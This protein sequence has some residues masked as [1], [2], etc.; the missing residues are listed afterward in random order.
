MCIYYLAGGCTEGENC[1]FAHSPEELAN[2]KTVMCPSGAKCTDSTCPFAH[3]KSELVVGH[4]RVIQQMCK[5]IGPGF[6]GCNAGDCCRFAHTR[7]EMLTGVRNQASNLL[8]DAGMVGGPSS[9]ASG[10]AF[11]PSTSQL[12]PHDAH[13]D[14]ITKDRVREAAR[15]LGLVSHDGV[16]ATYNEHGEIVWQLTTDQLL[17]LIKIASGGRLPVDTSD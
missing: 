4:Q 7:D 11:G 12:T 5:Y 3:D 8:G 17:N 6:R 16:G 13:P 1:T 15:V 10:M 14:L 9:R 2:P